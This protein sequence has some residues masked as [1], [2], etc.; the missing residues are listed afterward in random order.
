MEFIEKLDDNS[1]ENLLRPVWD[2]LIYDQTPQKADVI[3]AFGGLDISVPRRAADLYKQGFAPYILV[4]GN[5]GSRTPESFTRPEAMIFHD[6]IVVAGID[7]EKILI[8]QKATN[9]LENVKFGMEVLSSE[10]VDVNKAILTARPFLMRRCVATFNRHFPKV[11]VFSCPPK[12]SILSFCLR[13][14]KAFAERLIGE[15]QRL[16]EYSLKGDILLESIPR[17][18]LAASK[19]LESVLEH[20]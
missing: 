18:V 7:S 12:G 6:E 10:K 2:Y 20:S 5:A 17:E 11:K 8:E 4:T 9:A 19:E 3:F 1:F 13:S 15:V 14:R 16:E